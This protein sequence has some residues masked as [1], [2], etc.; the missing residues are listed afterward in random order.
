MQLL[1]MSFCCSDL[2]NCLE[3]KTLLKKCRCYASYISFL[4]FTFPRATKLIV[5]TFSLEDSAVYFWGRPEIIT[6]G[7][8]RITRLRVGPHL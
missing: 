2:S 7:L 3:V 4:R 6:L 1:Y 8:Y 5:F